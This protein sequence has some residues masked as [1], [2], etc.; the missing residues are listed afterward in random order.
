MHVLPAAQVYARIGSSVV[1]KFMTFPCAL[2]DFQMMKV[3]S[4]AQQEVGFET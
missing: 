3:S 2:A 1:S 4:P